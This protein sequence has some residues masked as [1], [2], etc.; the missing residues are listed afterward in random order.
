M[1]ELIV[2]TVIAIVLLVA[3]LILARGRDGSRPQEAISPSSLENCFPENARYFPSIRQAVSESDLAYISSRV[4]P[5]SLRLARAQR[6]DVVRKYLGGLRK[7][8]LQIEQLSRT[9]S[10]LSPSIT[11]RLEWERVW[12]GLQFRGLYFLARLRV[13]MGLNSIG[14]LT[15]LTD[16]VADLTARV[17]AIAVGMGQL[18]RST[19]T[20]Q[21]GGAHLA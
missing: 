21:G 10:S 17:E 5:A 9:L 8:F 19:S 4:K 15:Q 20:A 18:S 7:D 13:E 1:T 16:V 6:H 14:S 3:M 2:F 12:L 11:R